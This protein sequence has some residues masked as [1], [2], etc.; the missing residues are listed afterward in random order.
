MWQAAGAIIGGI[1]TTIGALDAAFGT[2]KKNVKIAQDA[3]NLSK[4]QYKE[5][6]RRYNEDKATLQKNADMVG[7]V[8]GGGDS[9]W[10]RN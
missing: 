8:F 3:L 5:E 2:G 1:G 6:N 10:N 7:S 4:E 9:V